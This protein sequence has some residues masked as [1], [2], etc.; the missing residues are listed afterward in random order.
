[1]EGGH[2]Q[3]AKS[4]DTGDELDTVC[5]KDGAKDGSQVSACAT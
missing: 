1:M 3:G 5:G 2:I 4:I